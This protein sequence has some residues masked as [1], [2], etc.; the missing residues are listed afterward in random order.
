MASVAHALRA[1]HSVRVEE[2]I[3]DLARPDSAEQLYAEVRNRRTGPV[4]LLVNNAGFGVYGDFADLPTP[5][6]Q[7]MICL[8]ILTVTKL[9]RLFLPEMRGRRSGAI[10]N[11]AS[12]AG[13]LPIPY[14]AMYGATKAFQVS[15][16]LGVSDEV[17][18]DGVI[19]QTCCP[20]HTMTGFHTTAGRNSPAPHASE[21][22][23]AQV[24]SE[25]LAA[26][27]RG[28]SFVIT[29]FRNRLLMRAQSLLPR[30]LVRWATLRAMKPSG[31][32]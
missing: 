15:L 1:A 4:D 24:V 29:G 28:K 13:L 3:M 8:H 2:I 32:R 17:R 26:L 21:Q 16:G 27:D 30:A 19:V 20:G 23:A 31:V 5:R 10:I 6:L 18:R 7:E 9:M 25:S 11:V 14:M 22:T 12:V